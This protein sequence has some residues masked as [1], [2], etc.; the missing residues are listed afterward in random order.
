MEL[1]CYAETLGQNSADYFFQFRPVDIAM[2]K[3]MDTQ[4]PLQDT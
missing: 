1:I 3:L 4:S 2:G